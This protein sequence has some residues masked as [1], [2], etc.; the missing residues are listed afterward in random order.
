MRHVA[1]SR[2]TE[3]ADEIRRATGGRGVDVV[4]NS[5]AGE[6]IPRSIDILAPAGRFIEIGKTGVWDTARVHARRPDVA[7]WVYYLGDVIDRDPA[8]V[9][10]RL[11]ALLELCASGELQPLPR[12][13]FPLDASSAAFR[14]MAQARHIGKVVLAPER[15]AIPARLRADGAYLV[16]GGLG[17]LG[18]HA[19]RWLIDH[20]ARHLVLT[21]RSL[22]D[23]LGAV[24]ELRRLATVDI[25]RSDV[26]SAGDVRRLISSFGA[27]RPALR[28][29]VHAAGALHD[30][31]LARQAWPDFRKGLG[32]KVLGTWH[33]HSATER[34]P[35]DFFVCYSSVASVIGSPGQ[36]SYAA[37]NAFMDGF[38]HVRRAEG[39]P[40]LSIGWGAWQ[41]GGMVARLGDLDRERW[42]A[43]GFRPL[44]DA[45]ADTV[46]NHVAALD[47]AHALAVPVNW[48]AYVARHPVRRALL[49]TVLH[50]ADQPARSVTVAHDPAL[51]TEL[52]RLPDEDRRPTLM[53]HVRGRILKLVGL[54]ADRVIDER[55]GFREVGLD[56]L[57][58]VELRNA[59]Q[60]DLNLVLPATMAFDYPTLATLAD[61][62]LG[63]L[64]LAN[65]ESSRAWR[66]RDVRR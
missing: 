27:T 32:A 39:L 11:K 61:F 46:L 25:E 16:T 30:G 31:M 38:A 14:F 18:L 65:L 53:R 58:A 23:N 24:D 19:A 43:E 50:A 45:D 48:Q 12:R 36:A 29:I 15:R 21:G 47:Q 60:A 52:A 1:D 20:G 41:R 28:G 6:F 13:V 44:S 7:Y 63:S 42:A 40:A 17:A 54:P 56:S 33:L 22:P 59:L 57:L 10:D 55:L 66:P 5:L 8:T 34:L 26:T 9:G 62:L 64:G 37:A 35:L 3:F 49:A 51:A 2:S 4:L